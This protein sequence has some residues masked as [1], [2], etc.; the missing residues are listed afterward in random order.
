MRSCCQLDR[1]LEAPAPSRGSAPMAS[2][3]CRPVGLWLL[4]GAGA[5]GCGSA[6]AALL[7]LSPSL[8]TSSVACVLLPGL[9]APGCSAQLHL[10]ESGKGSI[11]AEQA[12]V[13]SL[14]V[15]AAAWGGSR[16]DTHRRCLQS[17]STA[18]WWRRGSRTSLSHSSSCSSPSGWMVAPRILGTRSPSPASRLRRR[19][20]WDWTQT[21]GALTSSGIHPDT[22]T[23]TGRAQNCLSPED[24]SDKW[25]GAAPCYSS[26]HLWQLGQKKARKLFPLAST[27]VALESVEAERKSPALRFEGPPATARGAGVFR[28][29]QQGN[30]VTE[31]TVLGILVVRDMGTPLNSEEGQRD[32]S[33][34]QGFQG[35]TLPR[36]GGLCP[37]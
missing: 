6:R 16:A 10:V 18:G 33:W 26:I 36:T 34:K 12:S 24:T 15:S 3:L 7:S 32:S 17:K 5:S 29:A 11:S 4:P 14:S 21:A 37:E 2:Q 23:D 8:R 13:S 22:S 35:D 27:S 1:G 28:V 30:Q 20:S 25:K 9:R 31:G 19:T